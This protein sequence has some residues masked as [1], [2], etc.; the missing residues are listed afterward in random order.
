MANFWDKGH[1]NGQDASEIFLYLQNHP[2]CK[3]AA[4]S[5]SKVKGNFNKFLVGRSGVPRKRY[6][7]TELPLSFEEDVI[8]ALEEEVPELD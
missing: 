4:G 7:P 5:D 2:N 3:G 1:V 6:R 8:R